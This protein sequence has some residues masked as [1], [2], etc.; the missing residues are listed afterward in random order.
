MKT[1]SGKVAEQSVSYEI[2]EK[3][4]MES[5]NFHLK[6]WLIKLTYPVVASTCMLEQCMLS[7]LP[8]DFRVQNRARITAQ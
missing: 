6:Y 2:T 3:Y 7:V 8:N 5:V 4:R 1:Y